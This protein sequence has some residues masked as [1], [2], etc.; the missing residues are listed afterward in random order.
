VWLA[1]APN[2]TV[3]WTAGRND[4]PAM[5]SALWITYDVRLVWTGTNDG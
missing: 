3:T 1:T 2:V 5:G 4:T